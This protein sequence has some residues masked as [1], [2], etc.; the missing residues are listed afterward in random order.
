MPISLPDRGSLAPTSQAHK[1]PNRSFAAD[2]SSVGGIEYDPLAGGRGLI[3]GV[4]LSA[5][6][7]GGIA[8]LAM[9]I[10]AP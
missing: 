3:F 2:I 7:L 8:A 5:I 10:W 6:L 9:L 1:E 4:L